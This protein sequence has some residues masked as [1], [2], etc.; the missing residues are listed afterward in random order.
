MRGNYTLSN[1]ITYL[2]HGSFGAVPKVVQEDFRKWQ[3]MMEL[4]PVAFMWQT[5]PEAIGKSFSALGH[6]IGA[7][8]E[9]IGF[10]VNATQGVNAFAKSLP[11]EP[12]DEVLATNQE[13]GATQ[14]AMI[15]YCRQ[16]GAKYVVQEV[17]LPARGSR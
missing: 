10:V 17:P 5:T 13:Y 11:L 9:D 14:K 8:S 6:F 2:N 7:D 16:S 12:G 15:Y 1:E 3:E 4:N